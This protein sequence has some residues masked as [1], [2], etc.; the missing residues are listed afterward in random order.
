MAK[1]VTKT[2]LR[3]SLRDLR[4]EGMLTM[5]DAVTADDGEAVVDALEKIEGS[6]AALRVLV[7]NRYDFLFEEEAP[8]AAGAPGTI[9]VETEEEEEEEEEEDDD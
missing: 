3:D 8:A 2:M 1:R 9:V 4:D 7:E 5:K 6:V